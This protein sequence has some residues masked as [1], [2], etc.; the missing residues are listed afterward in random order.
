MKLWRADMEIDKALS[1]VEESFIKPIIQDPEITDVSFNG[2]FIF[3]QHNSFGRLKSDILI[4]QTE[5][6]DFIRQIANLTEQQF[7]FQN[8]LLDVSI[9]KYRINAVHQSIGRVDNKQAITFSIRISS[10]EPKIT[11]E[12]GY[13]SRELA[14]LFDVLLHSHCSMAI[15]GITGTG[16][17]EF[18]KYLLRKM[19]E[20]DRV[21]I[22]DNVLE[23]DQV[24]FNRNC[25]INSWQ[26]D[27][28]SPNSSIQ[29]LVKN[30]LRSNP[31]WLIVA[32]AR[33]PEMLDVF[34][35]MLTGHPIITTIHAQ[36]LESMPVRMT[37]M[38]MMADKR[39]DFNKIADDLNEHLHFY[40]YLNKSE[41]PDGSINRYIKEVGEMTR[42]GDFNILYSAITG[43]YSQISKQGR[44]LLKLSG[45]EPKIFRR[46]FLGEND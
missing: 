40:V 18:Q 37:R 8:P 36:N 33:G 44:K 15:G 27:D 19:N 29:T 22:I 25:D 38:I 41:N 46:T 3:F 39:T 9:G 34:N 10:V 7:S 5:A 4:N 45:D 26:L 14:S 1:F 35:S 32:E 16:K 17:T 11:D 28:R 12:S 6:R 43:E 20:K 24:R 30:A 21:I 2:E 13:L 23:L 42:D 31:D